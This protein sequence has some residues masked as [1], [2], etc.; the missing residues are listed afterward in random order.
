MSTKSETTDQQLLAL[1]AFAEML[2]ELHKQWTPHPKQLQPAFDLFY[3]GVKRQFMNLGRRFGK[4]ALMCYMAIRWALTRPKS[5]V[6]IVGPYLTTEREI[7]L[8]SG[9]LQDMIPRKY[10]VDYNK[11]EGRM[12]FT[13]GSFIRVMGADQPDS[14][15]GLEIDLL[16]IDEI[17][18]IKPDVIGIV[19]PTLMDNNAP[20]VMAGTP[21]DVPEHPFWERV[22][23]AQRHPKWR[24]YHGTSYD[25]PHISREALEEEREAYLARGDEDVFAR[26]FLAQYVPGGKRAVFPMLTTEHV[27]PYAMLWNRIQKN[28][29]QWQFYVTLDPGTASCFA[30]TLHAF[31]P[32]RGVVYVMDEVYEQQQSETSI[33]KMWPRIK[34]KMDELHLPEYDEGPWTVTVDEAATWA[35]NEL[36]DQFGFASFPT[37]KAQHRKA[38]GVSLLKDLLR[39]RKMLMSDRCVNTYK[40]MAGYMLDKNGGYIKKND[41]AIDTLRYTLAAANYTFQESN[42]PD[43][44]EVIPEDEKRRAFTPAEDFRDAFG[45]IYEPYLMDLMD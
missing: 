4:S 41:H 38:D 5:H 17:K 15:R 8:A 16:L 35:R 6:Y 29:H 33:G 42:A 13:N 11:T 26:E 7:I 2:E 45:P 39:S 10:F 14:L 44:P 23:T 18:D 30:A 37:T 22:E 36:L 32:Y 21:P 20:M 28:S 40:E 19:T 27:V 1:G 9:L 25:N 24:Y 31:N 34:S 12:N 3:G 43:R